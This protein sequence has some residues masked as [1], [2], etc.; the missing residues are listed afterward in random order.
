MNANRREKAMFGP[1]KH[2][3]K[4]AIQMAPKA[5]EARS[6]MGI[7]LDRQKKHPTAEAFH[8]KAIDL[9]PR[10]ARYR[11]NLGFCLFLQKRY[12]D[13]ET[14]VKE[15]IRLNPGMQR[16][17]NN[18]G[19]IYGLTDRED[20][21]MA[22]FTQAGSRAMALNNMGVVEEMKGRPLTAR[23]FYERALREDKSFKPAQINLKALNPQI[24]QEPKKT[25]AGDDSTAPE[26]AG[27][28]ERLAQPGGAK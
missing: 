24:E 17:F 28:K 20:Q 5:P 27:G 16:A 18:L 9:R 11:N 21:A 15:A 23:R 25:D 26:S 10:S 8:R 4:M 3:L 6:A 7:L 19:F 1:A 13:A 14:E 12:E 2:E 22:A